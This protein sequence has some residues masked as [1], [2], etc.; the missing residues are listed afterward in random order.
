MLTIIF[1]FTIDNLSVSVSAGNA[2]NTSAVKGAMG[3][4]VVLVGKIRVGTIVERN[5]QKQIVWTQAGKGTYLKS[6]QIVY[7]LA[8]SKCIIRMVDD[9]KLT[10]KPETK[11]I[12]NS[13]KLKISGKNKTYSI[14][15]ISGAT[16]IK[17]GK[18]STKFSVN[19][20]TS[21]CGVRGT[22]L[23]V[24]VSASGDTNIMVYEGKVEVTDAKGKDN[25]VAVSEKLTLDLNKD[26][27]AVKAPIEDFV[28]PGAGLFFQ[29]P[30]DLDKF[31]EKGKTELDKNPEILITNIN[32]A[33]DYNY[34]K[35]KQVKKE[36]NEL[37]KEIKSEITK[38]GDQLSENTTKKC[39]KVDE[40]LSAK[41]N[42]NEA[43]YE[44]AQLI[45]S[46]NSSN[47]NIMGIARQ[48]TGIYENTA[49]ME[50]EFNDIFVNL[51]K[52][53]DKFVDQQEYEDYWACF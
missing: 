42:Q 16:N 14:G 43:L 35:A 11:L 24:G 53:I 10:L 1:I 8:A 28:K 17:K 31:M 9:T 29:D 21:V 2:A 26:A 3:Q 5:N 7:T 45:A 46:K 36:V 18:N 6:N 25:E 15:V 33:L 49:K 20:P 51:D 38:L 44:I 48:C 39:V 4:V 32:E 30:K 23:I 41:F 37:E 19:T 52:E 47:N 50:R 12:I 40:L 27:E 13:Q 22:K 34:R